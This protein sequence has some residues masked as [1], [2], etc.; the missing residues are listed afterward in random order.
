MEKRGWPLLVV[1]LDTE[2]PILSAA[3]LKSGILLRKDEEKRVTP[4]IGYQVYSEY[5]VSNE[6]ALPES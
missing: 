5:K 1:E 4:R 2:Y 3:Q 6:A